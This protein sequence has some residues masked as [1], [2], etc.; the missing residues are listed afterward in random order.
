MKG[1]EGGL[2]SLT[3][4][5]EQSSSSLHQISSVV[6]LQPRKGGVK[7]GGVQSHEKF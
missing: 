5:R 4:N 7:E 2:C 3:P 1:F 6:S